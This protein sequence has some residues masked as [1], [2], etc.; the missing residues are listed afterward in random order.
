[1]VAVVVGRITSGRLGILRPGR[2][3]GGSSSRTIV[4]SKPR[5][6]RG[7]PVSNGPPRPVGRSFFSTRPT[8]EQREGL[9][10]GPGRRGGRVIYIRVTNPPPPPWPP[11]ASRRPRG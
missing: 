6:R 5:S 4:G 7:F 1:M 8:S 3:A 10:E 2:T 11:P 9:E